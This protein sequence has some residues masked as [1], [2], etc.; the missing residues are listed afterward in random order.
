MTAVG[1]RRGA[2]QGVA[3]VL[4]W[5]LLVIAVVAGAARGGRTDRFFR[6]FT[7]ASPSG[8]LR[9]AATS[10][11]NVNNQPFAS[12]FTIVVSDG[13]TGSVLWKRR[14]PREEAS[15]VQAWVHDGGAVVVRTAR[16]DLVVL[17]PVMGSTRATVALLPLFMAGQGRA[18]VSQTT[19]GPMWSGGSRW[20]FVE[21]GTELFF[22]LRTGWGERIAIDVLSGRLLEAVDTELE[23]VFAE[24]DRAWALGVLRRA[25]EAGDKDEQEVWTRWND[26]SAAMGIVV[27]HRLMDAEPALRALEES[28]YVGSSGGWFENGIAA[29]RVEPFNYAEYTTRA[30]AQMTLRR[31]GLRPS[32]R[33]ALRLYVAGRD[34]EFAPTPE[35][36]VERWE[37]AGLVEVGMTPEAVLEAL[38]NP[39]RLNFQ[40]VAW[41]YDLDAAEPYTL[42]V[43]WSRGR[44]V[45]R[46]VERAEAMWKDPGV[47]P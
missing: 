15:P 32:E 9:L 29:G 6:D 33:P 25:A 2:A 37:R 26:V 12:D 27:E 23:R 1:G 19:A 35:F 18:H 43:V 47:W 44:Y 39:D 16:D 3:G 7:E 45:V 24:D 21:R 41:E 14:Q 22:T 31:L 4:A 28:E 36:S 34:G 46:E 11:H 30:R 40:A 10:P 38:G 42:R 13:Q 5:S 8:R 17:D 20:G